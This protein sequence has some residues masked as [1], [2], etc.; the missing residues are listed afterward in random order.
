MQKNERLIERFIQ[1]GQAFVPQN[2]HGKGDAVLL[3]FRNGETETVDVRPE[4]FLK[5]LV[6]FFGTSVAVNRSRYGGLIGKRNLVPVALSYGLVL[7]PY[8]TRE[9]VGKQ[10]RTG[11]VF[12][13]EIGFM[14][15]TAQNKTYIHLAD[16]SRTL[17]VLHSQKFCL[18]QLKNAKCIELYYRE[19]HEPHRKAIAY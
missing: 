12:S 10:S 8:N 3:F 1:E 5:R 11:W 13:R 16:H 7:V 17:P 14:K 18:D 9:P 6:D 2:V 15:Q 4:L 19:I